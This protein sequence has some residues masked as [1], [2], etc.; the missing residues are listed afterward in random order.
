M[1]FLD[2]VG[3]W[4]LL[5]GRSRMIEREEVFRMIQAAY[6]EAADK[7]EMAENLLYLLGYGKR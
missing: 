6:E 3:A 7:D 2:W 5:R 1:G 4:Y